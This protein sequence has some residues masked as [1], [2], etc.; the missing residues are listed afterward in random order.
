ME[1]A[2]VTGVIVITGDIKLKQKTDITYTETDQPFV[3]L[4]ISMP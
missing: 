1:N 3:G 2:T 4:T